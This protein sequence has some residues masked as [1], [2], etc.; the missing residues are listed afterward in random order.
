MRKIYECEGR[1]KKEDFFF[2]FFLSSNVHLQNSKKN[3]SLSKLS[4]VSSDCLFL[5]GRNGD[6][7]PL[8][9]YIYRERVKMWRQFSHSFDWGIRTIQC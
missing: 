4:K 2:F 5:K 3:G 8:P 9:S 6:R 7:N 1:R